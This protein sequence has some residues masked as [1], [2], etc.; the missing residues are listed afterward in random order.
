[1]RKVG[2]GMAKDT[3]EEM[4]EKAVI[5]EIIEAKVEEYR[6]LNESEKIAMSSAC[7]RKS[8]RHLDTTHFFTMNNARRKRTNDFLNARKVFEIMNK[9]KL[10]IQE[11]PLDELHP[12]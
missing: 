4:V 8:L 2:E 11:S 12:V 1:M 3:I 6:N 10:Q 7:H 5:G 9:H